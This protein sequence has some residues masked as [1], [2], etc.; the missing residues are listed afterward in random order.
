MG[1][2]CPNS[3]LAI[4]PNISQFDWVLSKNRG[5]NSSPSVLWWSE[6][7][8]YG[9]KKAEK[10]VNRT[11]KWNGHFKF[12]FLVQGYALWHNGLNLQLTHLHALSESWLDIWSLHFQSSF[13]LMHMRKQH[14]IARPKYWGPGHM[15]GR[16]GWSSW[17]L[18]STWPRQVS[19]GHLESESWMEDLKA[20]V[21]VCAYFSVCERDCI[22]QISKS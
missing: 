12:N 11:K 14:I 7:R 19:C 20:C 15:Y 9:Q 22:F 13:L 4:V 18:A 10:S 16:P 3:T 5:S 2:G 1:C 17:L 8:F 21:C 6:D